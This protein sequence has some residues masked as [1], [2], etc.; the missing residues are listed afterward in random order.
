MTVLSI[1]DTAYELLLLCN[2]KMESHFSVSNFQVELS[3]PE[4]CERDIW[5]LLEECW[6]RE[7]EGRPT[8]S[9]ISMFLKRKSLATSNEVENK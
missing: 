4:S 2:K 9:E 1:W 6:N 8:F 3:Q 7:E 5:E